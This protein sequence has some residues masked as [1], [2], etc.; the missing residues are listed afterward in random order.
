MQLLLARVRAA[1]PAFSLADRKSPAAGDTVR[2]AGW[3]AA[4]PGVGRG[5]AARSAARRCWCSSCGAARQRPA[6]LHLAAANP[7]QRG[8]TS[9]HLAGG[10]RL[11]RAHADPMRSKT[12]F[13][14]W[15]CSWAAVRPRRR[16]P[17]PLPTRACWPQ[18]ARANLVAFDGSGRP[19]WRPCAP[20]PMNNW[21]ATGTVGGVPA[22]IMPA[23]Y[24]AFARQVSPDCSATIRPRGCRRA[25]ADHD[26]CLA[27][28][29]WAWR[30]GRAR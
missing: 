3:A 23:I 15:A 16:R 30:T 1:D 2:G 24:A 4:G 11:E 10:H 12:P 5:A 27:A 21:L 9:P 26:N 19:C 28:L 22:A 13:Y 20:M 6:L 17:W 18:L 25:L 7:A 14:A 29:R 8:R